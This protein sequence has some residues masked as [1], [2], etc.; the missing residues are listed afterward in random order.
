MLLDTGPHVDTDFV[1][2]SSVGGVMTSIR[3]RSYSKSII[4]RR[5]EIRAWRFFGD[6]YHA[7]VVAFTAIAA[8]WGMAKGG[9]VRA[10]PPDNDATGS[11]VLGSRA[12][13]AP[14]MPVAPTQDHA[15]DAIEF[16]A[17]AGFATDYIYRGVTLSDRKPALGAGLEATIGSFYAGTTVTSVKLPSQPAAEVTVS[18]GLRPKFG[19][20]E[21]DFGWTYFLYPGEIPAVPG[22]DYWEVGTRADTKLTESLRVAAGYAYSPNFSNTGAWSQYVATGLGIDLPRSV[23]P[24]NISASITGGAGYYWFGNQSAEFGGFALPA[25]FNW[26][27]GVTLTRN[28][29]NLDLRYYDTNLS[30]ENCFV[31]TGDPHATPGGQI[32]PV[33]NPEGLTSRWCGATF[34]ARF[35]FELNAGAK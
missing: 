23:M 30:K 15:A 24:G 22:I 8:L 27:A 33:T 26:N 16:N 12:G 6:G 31:F 20:I 21:L 13:L 9:S 10:E 25:Y 17:R 34:V 32:N 29:F 3:S 35:W 14:G 2:R 28:I 11:I 5:P 19:N 4:T 7:S 1:G 18:S